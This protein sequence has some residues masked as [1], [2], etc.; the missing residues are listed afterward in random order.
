M[1]VYPG[2]IFLLCLEIIKERY[3]SALHDPFPA[4]YAEGTCFHHVFLAQQL[5]RK[6]SELAT[7]LY[8]RNAKLMRETR[9]DLN[10]NIY[11]QEGPYGLTAQPAKSVSTSQ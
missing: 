3:A 4:I 1:G 6:F 5:P 7:N 2:A 8:S 9:A 11:C 10:V